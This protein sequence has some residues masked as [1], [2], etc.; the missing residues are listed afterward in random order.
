MAPIRKRNPILDNFEILEDKSECICRISECNKKFKGVVIGNLKRHILH[1]HKSEI[2]NINCRASSNES[3]TNTKVSLPNKP[4][5]KISMNVATINRACV[6]LIAIDSMPIRILN[7]EGFREIVD[8]ICN[9]LGVTVN[10][11]NF[12]IKLDFVGKKTREIISGELKNRIFCMKIDSAT[13]HGRSVLGINAQFIDNSIQ[14]RTLGMVEL[15]ERHTSQYLKSEV[16]KILLSY[17]CKLAQ[18][19]CCTIDNGANM[20]KCIN[21]LEMAQETASEIELNDTVDEDL[22][23]DVERSMQGIGIL[24]CVRCA[25]H[26]LQLAV[27]DV[28]KVEEISCHIKSIRDKIKKAKSVT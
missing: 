20:V 12:L 14:I 10:S 13:R 15:T 26:T 17:Q 24:R 19:L 11:H 5:L 27:N 1:C 9:A 28:I 25:S 3:S 22:T 2:E 21:L 23:T 4:N 6:K 18:V 16:E 7:S 8:P